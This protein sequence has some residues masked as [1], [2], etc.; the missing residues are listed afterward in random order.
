VWWLAT[1]SEQQQQYEKAGALYLRA[2]S[3]YEH[4]LGAQHP[5]TQRIRANYARLLRTMG[6]EAEAAALDQP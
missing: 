4:A 5:T 6:R 1:L 3:I 2:L